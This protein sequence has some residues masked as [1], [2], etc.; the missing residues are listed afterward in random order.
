MLHHGPPP[1]LENADLPHYSFKGYII[2]HSIIRQQF[3]PIGECLD[4]QS[5]RQCHKEHALNS[6]QFMLVSVP[7]LAQLGCMLGEE[8]EPWRWRQTCPE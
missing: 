6:I 1:L 2:F 5:Y 8:D 3:P 7:L 4:C